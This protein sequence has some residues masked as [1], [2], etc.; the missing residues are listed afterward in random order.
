MASKSGV[1]WVALSN[2]SH[3]DS[4]DVAD[5]AEP[6]RSDAI[7]FLQALQDA[8]ATVVISATRRSEARAYLFHWSWCIAQGSARASDV[9]PKA[10]LDILW[11]HGTDADS[12]R[13]AADMVRGFGLAVPPRSVNPPSLTSNHI[14]G[15]AI[16][17]TVTWTGVLAAKK[18][19]G[20]TVNVPF[21]P[22]VNLNLPLH[23]V[24]ASYGVR[25]LTTD[26]PHWSHNG[27]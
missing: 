13:A 5:L 11:D 27:R 7:A 8:G 17:M 14:A 25:K 24:G 26:A 22:D 20:T 10:G 9:P 16:D 18:R 15:T 23:E 3:G 1:S 12:V 4:A 2:A 21:M 19:D 6:F